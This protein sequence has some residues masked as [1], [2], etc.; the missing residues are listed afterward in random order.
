MK[1]GKIDKARMAEA[2]RERG[3]EREI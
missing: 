2:K 1:N 3:K